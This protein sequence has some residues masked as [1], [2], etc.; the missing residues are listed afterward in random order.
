MN[1][2]HSKIET[3][4]ASKLVLELLIVIALISVIESI[5][6]NWDEAAYKKE[7]R[8][9]LARGYGADDIPEPGYE[10]AALFLCFIYYFIWYFRMLIIT[11]TNTVETLKFEWMDKLLFVASIP[12]FLLILFI[13][14]VLVLLTT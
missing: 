9:A 3:S 11:K 7:F 13:I 5:A 1:L 14:S 6:T 8:N 10:L 2:L 12:I 4:K